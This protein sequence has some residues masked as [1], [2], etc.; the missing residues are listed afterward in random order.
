MLYSEPAAGQALVARVPTLGRG[1]TRS[2][3]KVRV[4]GKRGGGQGALVGAAFG[5]AC[6]GQRVPHGGG[7]Q[8]QQQSA[9][10]TGPSRPRAG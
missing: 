6:S 10:S 5:S 4:A 1:M 3:G 9:A 8:I 2:G 7:Q